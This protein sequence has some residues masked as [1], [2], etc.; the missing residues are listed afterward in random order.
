MLEKQIVFRWLAYSAPE[1]HGGVSPSP[2][3]CVSKRRIFVFLPSAMLGARGVLGVT[4]ARVPVCKIATTVGDNT[5]HSGSVP[6]LAFS[7]LTF[8]N[9]T[10]GRSRFA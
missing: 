1:S 5:H 8:T 6:W 4:F 9:L 2:A 3:L 7:F 10:A